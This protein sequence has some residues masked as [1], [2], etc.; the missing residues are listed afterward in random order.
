[1]SDDTYKTVREAVEACLDHADQTTDRIIEE[2]GAA[3][4]MMT[5]ADKL[6]LRN[7]AQLT[8]VRTVLDRLDKP[9]QTKGD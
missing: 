3:A 2:M 9:K 1:M 6:Y 4:E 8:A 7:R 5:E